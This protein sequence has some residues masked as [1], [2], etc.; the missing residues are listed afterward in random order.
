MQHAAAVA[1][2]V[3]CHFRA[4]HVGPRIL[5]GIAGCDMESVLGHD[6]IGRGG[7]ADDLVQRISGKLI[8]DVAT[9]AGSGRCRHSGLGEAI[10]ALSTE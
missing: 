1:A 7:T 5:F 9:T 4:T 3:D 6:H 8:L 2:E 10:S